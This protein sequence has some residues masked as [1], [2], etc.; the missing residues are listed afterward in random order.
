[1]SYLGQTANYDKRIQYWTRGATVTDNAEITV[2]TGKPV[3][4]I[5]KVV[6]R[7]TGREHVRVL[8]SGKRRISCK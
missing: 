1:M 2:N 3:K 6:L 5:T 8:K 7:P 4:R